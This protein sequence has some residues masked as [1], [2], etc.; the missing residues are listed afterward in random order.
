MTLDYS[1]QH[2]L[3]GN[4]KHDDTE[5]DN[6]NGFLIRIF[7]LYLIKVLN[8]EHSLTQFF[9]VHHRWYDY[10]IG[11]LMTIFSVFMM[12]EGLFCIYDCESET[13]TPIWLI[14]HGATR[15]I[16]ILFYISIILSNK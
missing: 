4:I 5:K 7:F 6:Q 1:S 8:I 14:V 13:S 2:K 10:V 16:I 11:F 9:L 15:L 3:N 12:V